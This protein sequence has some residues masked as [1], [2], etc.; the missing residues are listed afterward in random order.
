MGQAHHRK[1][2]AQVSEQARG[3]AGSV[4]LRTRC[5]RHACHNRSDDDEGYQSHDGSGVVGLHELPDDDD[6]RQS[7]A[8]D[9]RL[10]AVDRGC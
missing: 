9:C 3:R 6:A 2:Q 4:A 1:T 7:Y 5:D 8:V 10:L